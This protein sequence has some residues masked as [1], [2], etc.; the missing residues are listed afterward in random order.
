M[1]AVVYR[2]RSRL[3]A[4]YTTGSPDISGL[5]FSDAAPDVTVNARTR[6]GRI[7]MLTQGTA[8]RQS[9]CEARAIRESMLPITE[10]R[11]HDRI[12][13]KKSN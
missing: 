6:S 4:A 8:L 9:R 1:R 7:T 2:E 10:S 3:V 11:D 12:F 13:I 5:D